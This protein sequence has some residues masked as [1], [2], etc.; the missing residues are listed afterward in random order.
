MFRSFIGKHEPVTSSTIARWVKSCLQQ[1]GV[2]TSKFK[3]HSTRAA[4][5]AK[6]AMSGLSVEDIMIGQVKEFF[7]SFT[8]GHNTVE[9]GS[10]VLKAS[11]SKSH[12]DMETKPSEVCLRSCNG[13]MLFVII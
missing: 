1:A 7:R 3:V 2:D 8:T 6:A 4:A 13:R 12:A 9:F 11:A 10:S 5:A